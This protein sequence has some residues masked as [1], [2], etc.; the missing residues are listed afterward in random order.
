MCPPEP[1]WP[2]AED[3]GINSETVNKKGASSGGPSTWLLGLYIWASSARRCGDKSSQSA[4]FRLHASSAAP[5]D[6]NSDC[7][8]FRLQATG[9]RY[10]INEHQSDRPEQ[11]R[12]YGDVFFLI[13]RDDM[14]Q[15]DGCGSR[16]ADGPSCKHIITASTSVK[17]PIH[18][19]STEYRTMHA[20]RAVV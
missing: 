16:R 5:R 11:W 8:V 15:H 6:R 10:N 18:T 12:L 19:L 9:R 17:R 7:H 4:S 1:V 2:H 3:D 13:D 20:K 14:D